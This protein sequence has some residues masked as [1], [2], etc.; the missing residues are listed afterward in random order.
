M[1]ND[2]VRLNARAVPMLSQLVEEEHSRV[3]I[4]THADF[5]PI[6]QA[7]EGVVAEDLQK[8]LWCNEAARII[9]N[10]YGSHLFRLSS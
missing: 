5:Q 8:P 3:D 4:H 10:S 7:L 2:H 6:H 1:G 9:T